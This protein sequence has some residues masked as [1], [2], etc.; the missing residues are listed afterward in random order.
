[1]AASFPAALRTENESIATV[2]GARRTPVNAARTF[3]LDIPHQPIPRTFVEVGGAWAELCG[4][5]GGKGNVGYGPDNGVCYECN[6]SGH[7]ARISEADL[8]RRIS[9]WAARAVAESEK[10][11]RRIAG[12]DAQRQQWREENAEL[13]AW[14]QGLRPSRVEYDADG[15]TKRAATREEAETPDGR[16]EGEEFIRSQ[17]LDT[18]S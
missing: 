5:C 2:G 16:E 12:R 18:R 3:S 11:E 7:G 1:M 13:I 10:T 17:Q 8:N 15:Y 4:R 14:A 9:K 6:G